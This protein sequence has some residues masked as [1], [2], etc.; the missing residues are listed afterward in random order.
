MKKE[1][2]SLVAQSVRL[3]CKQLRLPQVAAQFEKLATE[4]EAQQ[5]SYASYLGALLQAEVEERERR[6]ISRRLKEAHL[7]RMKTLEEFDF[8][9]SGNASAQ[10]IRELAQGGYLERSEPVILIGDCGTGKTHLATGLLVEACRQK[11]RCRFV[12]AAGLVNDL[13]E[14]QGQNQLGRAL[15]RWTRY[16]LI[17]IDEVGYVPFAEVGVELL[18]SARHGLKLFIKLTARRFYLECGGPDAAFHS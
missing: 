5:Q 2:L 13:V 1:L 3:H 10:R 6:V 11:R 18:Y 14:A 7:P 8:S 17:V 9:K 16:E 15:G 12:T 4:A